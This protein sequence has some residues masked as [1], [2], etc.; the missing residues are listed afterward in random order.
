[1]LRHVLGQPIP[2][3]IAGLYT[4]A[5]GMLNGKKQSFAQRW[6]KPGLSLLA[7]IFVV[8]FFIASFPGRAKGSDFP[9]FYAAARMV[10][11]GQGHQLYDPA[12]QEEFQ[13]RYAGRIGT[14]FIHP[15]FE[16]LIYLPFAL[17]PLTTAYA[18]WTWFNG[19][20]LVVLS[21]VLSRDVLEP[22]TWP[23]V[24]AGLFLFPPVLLN[25]FEGQDALLLLLLVMAAIL[26]LKGKNDIAAGCFLACGLFKFHLIVA[27]VVLVLRLRRVRTL[28]AFAACAGLL[29]LLS[30]GIC[31]SEALTSYSQLLIHINGLPLAAIHPAQMANLRGLVALCGLQGMEGIVITFLL[32]LATVLLPVFMVGV[33]MPINPPAFDL[34]A[35]AFLLAATLVSYHIIPHDFT[36]LLLP[37]A[38]AVR[39]LIDTRDVPV[40]L[41]VCTI[42]L[43]SVLFLPPLHI[44]LMSRHLYSLTSIP[45]I[46]FFFCICW[47]LRR[48]AKVGPAI[49]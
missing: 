34:M 4:H 35:A 30:V 15:P 44:I 32:S 3:N 1:V 46:G 36:L 33:R 37:L 27:L 5:K 26:A 49:A 39:H 16:A 29:I 11:E 47:E 18:L 31:G 6:V 20:L 8:H 42:A 28:M 21:L 14:Y 23:V 22:L 12:V 17:F 24:L 13:I 2:C 40:W 7:L 9:E 38:L 45:V 25:F 10:I 43:S 19:G 48:I 41:R